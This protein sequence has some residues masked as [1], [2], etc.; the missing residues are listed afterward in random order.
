MYNNSIMLAGQVGCGKI[1]L[2]LAIANKLIDEGI[3]KYV[4]EIEPIAT[5]YGLG[6]VINF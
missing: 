4:D 3:K 1:R 5:N 2:C 6:V